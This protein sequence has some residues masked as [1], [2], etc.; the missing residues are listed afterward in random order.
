[1]RA[2]LNIPDNLVSEVQK[3][4]GEKSKTNA[5]ITAMKAFV[6]QKKVKE[7]IALRGKVQIDYDWQKEEELEMKAQKE[8][9][10]Q[11]GRKK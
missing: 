4:S 7:L 2:T 11:H 6:R 8:R 10:K 5:I 1:M 3:L 9:E